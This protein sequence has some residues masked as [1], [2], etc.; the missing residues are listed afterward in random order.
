M[1]LRTLWI[2]KKEHLDSEPN[3]D[4]PFIMIW[5]T[6]A[7][8]RQVTGHVESENRSGDSFG[9]VFGG[10]L[11]YCSWPK[12]DTVAL[13][14]VPLPRFYLGI[15]VARQHSQPN[16]NHTS[17]APMKAYKPLLSSF[18]HYSTLGS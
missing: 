11:Y 8:G 13:P 2:C 9:S 4:L 7:Q 3:S 1:G 14:M 17:T 6:I 12:S 16:G 10:Y 5:T 18:T 15:L